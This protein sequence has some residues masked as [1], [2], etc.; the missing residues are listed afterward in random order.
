ME[1]S[2]SP[3]PQ[4]TFTNY[5]PRRSQA[6]DNARNAYR[7]ATGSA[8]APRVEHSAPRAKAD[9][10]HSSER[11]E[12]AV[13]HESTAPRRPYAPRRTDVA[14]PTAGR[15]IRFVHSEEPRKRVRTQ[16][17]QRRSTTSPALVQRPN[18]D[19]RPIAVQ[20]VTDPDIVRIGVVSGAEG[21]GRN[22]YFY[23]DKDNIVIF[24]CGLQFVSPLHNAPGVNFILPNTQYLEANKHKIRGMFITHGHLDHIG[25]IQFLIER[26]GYPRIYT[27]YLTSLLILKRH[28]EYP[29][30]DPLDMQVIKEGESITFSTGLKVKSFPVT[31]SIPDAMGLMVETPWG[32]VVFTGDVRLD[33][34]DEE[35]VGEEKRYWESVGAQKN[36][37]ML[38]DSTNCDRHGFS[39]PEGIVFENL[40]KYIRDTKGRLVIGTFASQF[41][42][43]TSIVNSCKEFGRVIVPEGRSIKTNLDI[44]IKAG[45]IEVPAGLIVSAPEAEKYPREKIVILA[46]GAQGEEFAAMSRIATG[47][48]KFFKLDQ[49]DTVLLSSSV[50]PGNELAVQSL[51]DKI[52]RNNSRV[53]TYQG[54]NIHASGHGYSGEMNWIRRTVAPKFLMPIH[55]NHFH[56]KSHMYAAIADG[57]TRENVVVPDNGSVIEIYK[58]EMLRVLPDKMPNEDLTVDGLSVGLRQEVVLRDRIALSNDGMF[59]VVASLDTRT[60]KLRKSPD[61][62]SRGFIYLRENQQLLND[63]RT[64]VRDQIERS[65]ANSRH[66][67]LDVLRDEVT[68]SLTKFLLQQT[69]K[70]P[71]VIPVIIGF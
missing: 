26:L 24:D 60:G 47:D 18:T 35:V 54:D 68:D 17:R 46:T 62:I 25:G 13:R 30:L 7:A 36:L 1:P 3:R 40:R 34:K 45:I 50:I 63:A 28:E 39:Q 14:A 70:T 31:H 41:E 6:A 27:Q 10:P 21:I 16:A 23:E 52:F 19:I 66:I 20:P 43:L 49:Y 2:S 29:H 15:G 38:A 42:R 57:F 44:A 4:R 48:H 22:M 12:R 64:M 65:T 61:I 55:G 11:A 8:R 51:K 58:G 33:H 37:I 5:G 53:V 32:N 69:N 59:V 9:V 67:D 71:I 56:L